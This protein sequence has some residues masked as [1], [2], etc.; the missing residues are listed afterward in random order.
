MK[1]IAK[2]A[3]IGKYQLMDY[4]GG[5]NWKVEQT[6]ETSQDAYKYARDNGFQ[7]VEPNPFAHGYSDIYIKRST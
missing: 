6:F 7:V 5:G 4:V 3:G 1:E 2:F